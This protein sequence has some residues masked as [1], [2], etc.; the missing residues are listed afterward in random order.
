MLRAWKINA[1][2]APEP[3]A[4]DAGTLD[5]VSRRLPQGFYSTFRTFGNR[6]RALELKLHLARLYQ[7]AAA[8]GV[9]PAVDQRV[10]R[11]TLRELLEGGRSTGSAQDDAFDEARVRISLSVEEQPGSVFVAIEPLKRLPEEVYRQ[12]VRVV[13]SYVARADPRLKSTVFIRQSEEARRVVSQGGAFEGLI[14]RHARILEGLTSNFYY[15]Q[16][17][18][19]GTAHKGVL[20]G[21]TRRLV[22]QLARAEGL[23]I[24]LRALRVAKIQTLSEAFITSSSRG[25]VPVVA[26]DDLPVATGRVGPVTRR[27]MERYTEFVETR[28]ELI[29]LSPP[30]YRNARSLD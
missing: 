2:A 4:L 15:V 1:G 8:L 23:E 27:L 20:L 12:G 21:V 26:V 30:L 9:Q 7:P 22:L 18:V 29:W 28:A 13:S 6:T 16:E 19:L 14:V 17:R 25:I 10:L 11:R 3:L 5:E 24:V